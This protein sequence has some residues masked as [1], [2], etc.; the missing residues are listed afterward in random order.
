MKRSVTVW[1]AVFALFGGGLRWLD[2]SFFTDTATGF[3]M[4]PVWLRYVLL[5]IWLL[6]FLLA[7][8]KTAGKLVPGRRLSNLAQI[9]GGAYGAVVLMQLSHSL[10]LTES[11]QMNLFLTV[12]LVVLA[13]WLILVGLCWRRFG[14]K[15]G[16]PLHLG[17]GASLYFLLQTFLCGLTQAAHLAHIDIVWQALAYMAALC[18]CIKLLR[19]ATIPAETDSR[20]LWVTGMA[21]FLLCTCLHLPQYYWWVMQGIRAQSALPAAAALGLFGLLGLGCALSVTAEK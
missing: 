18:F 21:A 3:A 11:G 8:R 4:G 1:L 15:M 6:V 7:G 13:G 16:L 20:G 17:I 5:A 19:A 9:C 14:T 10:E 12:L 2:L